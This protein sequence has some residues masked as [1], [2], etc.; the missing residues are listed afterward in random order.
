MAET[1]KMYNL[2]TVS[3]LNLFLFLLFNS[4]VGPNTHSV[5]ILSLDKNAIYVLKRQK[6]FWTS[7]EYIT[8]QEGRDNLILGL[9]VT[10]HNLYIF[11]ARCNIN[12]WTYRN[13]FHSAPKMEKVV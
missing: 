9:F 1:S 8:S 12:D 11:C 2:F 7:K 10:S 4:L 5:F 6:F 3:R 13:L